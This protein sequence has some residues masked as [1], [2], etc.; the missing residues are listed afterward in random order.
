MKRRLLNSGSLW[1]GC[2]P[3]RP[4]GRVPVLL[5]LSLCSTAATL[6]LLLALSLQQRPAQPAVADV[7]MI[8]HKAKEKWTA[9]EL[10]A[11]E[12]KARSANLGRA[13]EGIIRRLAEE[14]GLRVFTAGA[15]IYGAEDI[16]AEVM[17]LLSEEGAW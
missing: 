4:G 15:V 7:R 17:R 11:A 13:L 2:R 1:S 12:L 10:G 16:S 5:P 8:L 14:R 6:A 9:E 3:A